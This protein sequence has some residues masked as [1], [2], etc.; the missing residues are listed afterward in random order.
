MSGWQLPI[1]LGRGGS[2]KTINNLP[3]KTIQDE[4]S[5]ANAL[6][7]I[8]NVLNVEYLTNEQKQIVK[9][10]WNNKYTGVQSSPNMGKTFISACIIQLTWEGNYKVF[11]DR[12]GI[13]LIGNPLFANE[14]KIAWL[15]LEEGMTDLTPQDP[16]FTGKSL[17]DYFNDERIDFYNARKI[18]NPKDWDSYNPISKGAVKFWEILKGSSE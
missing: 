5:A 4:T 18:I 15:I 7:F 17:E 14:P 1:D 13:D 2:K 10:V 3:K 11:G 8:K 9:S 16:E 12:I 6:H